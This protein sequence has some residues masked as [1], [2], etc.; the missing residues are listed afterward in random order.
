MLRQLY[1]GFIDVPLETVKIVINSQ[2]LAFLFHANNGSYIM[3]V[4]YKHASLAIKT[5]FYIST[6][7]T[8]GL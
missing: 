8:I 6:K 3:N 5:N 4:M 1:H 2:R 7:F